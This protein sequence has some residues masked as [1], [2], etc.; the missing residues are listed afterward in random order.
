MPNLHDRSADIFNGA[1]ETRMGWND[2][3][4]D[5][6][7]IPDYSF[8]CQSLKD[9]NTFILSPT[10]GTPDRL[11][12]KFD[13]CPL[14]YRWSYPATETQVESV[15]RALEASIDPATENGQV[16][17]NLELLDLAE[18]ELRLIFDGG[19]VE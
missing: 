15:R 13:P 18:R 1:E 16:W 10:V 14:G 7:G 4:C 19:L 12:G 5:G 17:F 11:D 3:S 6:E 8:A 9:L 2:E